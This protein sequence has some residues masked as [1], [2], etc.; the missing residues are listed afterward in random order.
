[1]WDSSVSIVTA[2]KPNGRGLIPRSGRNFPPRR[3]LK[4]GCVLQ[5][6]LLF[7]WRQLRLIAGESGHSAR[8]HMRLQG[9]TIKN[10]S[11]FPLAK[12]GFS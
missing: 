4:S 1:M 7:S 6:E 8:S 11:A 12:D 3:P 9:V 5:P 10:R 2:Y